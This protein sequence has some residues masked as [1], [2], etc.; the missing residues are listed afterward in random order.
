MAKAWRFRAIACYARR[1][2]GKQT[3]GDLVGTAN[4]GD[5]LGGIRCRLSELLSPPRL[6]FRHGAKEADSTEEVAIL[7]AV[8]ER[9]WERL[10]SLLGAADEDLGHI[11]GCWAKLPPATRQALRTLVRCV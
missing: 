8:R 3:Q 7:G 5:V 2:Q 11:V 1:P 4:S 10:G 9:D 6:S